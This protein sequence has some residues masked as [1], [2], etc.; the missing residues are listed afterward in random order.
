MKREGEEQREPSK[1][2]FT[3]VPAI[4]LTCVHLK[5]P[6]LCI[7]PL[8]RLC[9]ID[10]SLTAHVWIRCLLC[11]R[12]CS[13][14]KERLVQWGALRAH[15]FGVLYCFQRKRPSFSRRSPPPGASALVGV[16]LRLSR[17]H[18]E[19]HRWTSEQAA[20]A[21]EAAGHVPRGLYPVPSP[22]QNSRGL[23][24]PHAHP[25]SVLLVFEILSISMC[26]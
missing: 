23:T 14:T 15:L 25:C 12:S 19:Q 9:F 8:D 6:R 1:F 24:D 26:L 4:G 10:C 21:A 17:F 7:I 18:L 3:V 5:T 2:E 13:I 20:F 16:V 22:Q 11:L